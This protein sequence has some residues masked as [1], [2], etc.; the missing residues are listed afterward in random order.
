MKYKFQINKKIIQIFFSFALISQIV[1]LLLFPITVKA[2][3]VNDEKYKLAE[4]FEK[5]GDLE[6]ASRLFIEL[7]NSNPTSELYFSSVVRTLR[8]LNKFSTLLPII[9][10]RLQNF[11][12]S[13]I[14]T[15]YGEM[16]WRTGKPDN[17]NNA[18]NEALQYKTKDG[19][20]F[21]DVAHSQISLQLYEKAIQTYEAGRKGLSNKLVFADELSQLYILTG[22][23]IK[24][25]EEVMKLFAVNKNL[26][27]IQGRLS[28]L[29]TGKNS[30]EYI[31]DILQKEISGSNNDQ[32]YLRLYAWFL[33]SVNK[34][35]KALEIYKKLD[36]LT[37]SVGMELFRF[38]GES[39]IDGQFDM[40]LK[41]YDLVIAKGRNSPYFLSAMFGFARTLENKSQNNEKLTQDELDNIIKRYRKII[42]DYPQDQTS[43][44]ARFRIASLSVEQ[45]KDYETATTELNQIIKQ[46][47]TLPITAQA[48]LMLGSL[49]MQKDD[50]ESAAKFYRQVAERF[51]RISPSDADKGLLKLAE[52]EYYKGNIDT[53]LTLFIKISMNTGSDASNDAL[54]K[55]LLIEQNKQLTQALSKFAK[56]ELLELQNKTEK[57]E[58]LYKEVIKIADETDLEERAVIK[59][60]Q[61][62]FKKEDFLNARV[63][64]QKAYE[65]NEDAIYA[66]KMMLFL[67]DIFSAEKNYDSALK[68][69]TDLIAKFPR[70]IYLQEA[71]DK[72]RK[73]RSLNKI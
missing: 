16:L 67:A 24:G 63:I 4:S 13:E 23:Y 33:R 55:I 18:W 64:L 59:I 2:Q 35:E 65:K 10:K 11:R 45:S 30:N 7:T 31:D 8:A 29:M 73:L 47:P 70:S 37:G 44:E 72:I 69:Y 26:P 6:N 61:I 38:A 46:F 22:D 56:A 39:R 53:S 51:S 1:L 50:F 34:Q 68:Y 21:V 28:A 41:G 58:E 62:L 66:D 52:L 32:Q 12:N 57:A 71:R 5:G 60:A 3:N 49:S 54:N 36:D 25:T 42:N 27:F 20:P 43:A 40:A 15:L 17:A 9:E 19:K 48:Y 14:L